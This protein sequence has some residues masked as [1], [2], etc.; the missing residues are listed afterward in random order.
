MLNFLKRI[1]HDPVISSVIAA[2]LIGFGSYFS[3]FWPLI[4]NFLIETITFLTKKTALPNWLI[5][6]LLLLSFLLLATKLIAA[7]RLLT[8]AKSASDYRQYSQDEFFGIRWRWKYSYGSGQPVELCPFCVKCDIQI[9][10]ADKS[11]YYGRGTLFKC[12]NTSC[13]AAA[14]EINEYLFEIEDK[15]AR[16]LQQKARAGNWRKK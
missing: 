10:P 4:K 15:V 7:V 12:D 14:I 6:F 3:P 1:W 2:I 16:H 11:S 9:R 5:G 8:S 13:D